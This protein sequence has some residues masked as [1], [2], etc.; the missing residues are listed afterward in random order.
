MKTTLTKFYD[1]VTRK[2]RFGTTICD[3][4]GI[5][6]EPKTKIKRANLGYN[7]RGYTVYDVLCLKCW[8][9]K[10]KTGITKSEKELAKYITE[11][12]K[13]IE[14]LKDELNEKKK[15]SDKPILIFIINSHGCHISQKQGKEWSD[16]VIRVNENK[17]DDNTNARKII[18]QIKKLKAFK[19]V[20]V[21]LD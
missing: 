8:K 3:S 2:N 14:E 7:E 9:R 4:C 19:N 10:L 16:V 11:E 18:K 21:E 1:S 15:V 12:K 17:F 13:R 6:I 5:N 20:K